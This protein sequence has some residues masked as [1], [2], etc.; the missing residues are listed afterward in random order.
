MS[1]FS[2]TF[3]LQ[4]IAREFVAA[5]NPRQGD[6]HLDINAL[7]DYALK[8]ED[9]ATNPLKIF[10]DIQSGIAATTTQDYDL[11][12]TLVDADGNAMSMDVVYMV[13]VYNAD[14]ANGISVGPKTGDPFGVAASNQG[15]WADVSDRSYVPPESP[16]I[17]ISKA[18]VPVTESTDTFQVITGGS[19]GNDWEV[20]IVG[21]DNA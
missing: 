2:I 21:R 17:L 19:G 18:G 4:C 14:T 12:G 16:L 1:T 11:F 3:G 5:T 9:S 7:R 8:L 15:F 20:L 13:I 6:R 10:H